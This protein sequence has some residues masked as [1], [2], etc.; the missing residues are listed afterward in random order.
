MTIK[1]IQNALIPALKSF[2]GC[3]V[4]KADQKGKRP[5]TKHV[6][7]KF[8]SP[9]TKDLG[10]G[11]EYGEGTAETYKLIREETYKVT[12][13][14][15]AYSMDDTESVELASQVRKWFGFYGQETLESYDLAVVSVS[16]VQNRDAFIIDDYERRNGFDV[17][18]RASN[19]LELDVGYI[20]KVEI[21]DKLY[22]GGS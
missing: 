6:T 22:E 17:V 15:D 5:E 9:D 16:D 7:F 14:F 21:N 8:S 11:I 18:L 13:S 20:E 12:L 10:M 1:E 2:C 3:P 19:R 4:I